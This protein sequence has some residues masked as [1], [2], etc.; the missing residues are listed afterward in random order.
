MI[1]RPQV[2]DNLHNWLIGFDNLLHQANSTYPPYNVL[3][4]HEDY[5]IDIAVAGFQPHEL[6]ITLSDNTLVVSGNKPDQPTEDLVYIHRGIASRSWTHRWK[7]NSSLEVGK[8]IL[9]DGILSIPI[10]HV[11]STNSK[12]KLEILT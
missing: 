1:T 3:K 7:L 11:E 6:D 12:V 2:F 10:S 9:R 5:R 4:E 8:P